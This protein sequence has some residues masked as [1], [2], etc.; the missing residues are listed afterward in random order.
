MRRSLESLEEHKREL[1]ATLHHLLG[2][3]EGARGLVLNLVTGFHAADIADILDVLEPDEAAKVL[4]LLDEETASDALTEME[5]AAR[6]A[7]MEQVAPHDIASLVEAMESDDAADVVADLPEERVQEVLKH[8]AE[9]D[10]EEIEELLVHEEDTAGGLMAAEFVAVPESASVTEAIEAIRQAVEETEAIYY[11]YVV[12]E[13]GRLTGL[14]SLRD[15]LLAPSARH[16]NDFMSSEV[17]S[18][19]VDMDQ[20]DVAHLVQ[21][22]D[23]A[24][25][26]VVDAEGRLVGRVTH[27]DIADV[28]EEE[29]E[30]D[31]RRL[32]GVSEGFFHERSS[33]RIAGSRLPWLMVSVFGALVAALVIHR[34][35]DLIR[36]LTAIAAFIPV[37]IAVAG[38]TGLQ[39][40][41]VVV[42]GLATGQADLVHIGRTV[43]REIRVGLIIGIVCGLLVGAVSW[44][45]LRQPE[46]GLVVGLSML[47]A[48]AVAATMGA[49]VPLTL[50]RLKADPALATGPFITMT[51]D[52]V[53]LLIYFGFAGTL[54]RAFGLI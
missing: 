43:F 20:E 49:A 7:V 2:Q 27:D 33:L 3:G 12:D 4:S 44:L 51:N 6:T 14:L 45:T 48:I 24:A 1:V 5:D 50:D 10:R 54:L 42:R 11:V 29:S 30:E 13:R 36:Q 46:M 19:P 26:P 35:E 16:V 39:S 32:A 31:F 40:S 15:L 17:V 25:I 23:L 8:V 18:V 47:S 53:G 21:Q 34:N 52:I 9:E 22:Y 28:L 37:I 38:S 41:I